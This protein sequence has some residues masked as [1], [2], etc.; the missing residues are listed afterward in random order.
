M[1]YLY[2]I[3][4]IFILFCHSNTCNS[5]V[6][7]YILHDSCI[8]ELYKTAYE[9]IKNDDIYILRD[10]QGI[11][12]RFPIVDCKKE[13]YNLSDSTLKNLVNIEKFLAKIKNP[14]II[15]VHTDGAKQEIIKGLKN[16][17]VS[18][19]IA[20]NI[21]TAVVNNG[22]IAENNRILSVGYGEFLPLKNTPNNGGK[23]L[24]RVDIIVLCNVSGE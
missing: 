14:V 21:R 19:V 20:D 22:D 7:R 10:S 6:F 1:R 18:T 13:Y 8:S 11:I 2:K 9:N 4:C 17:E 23:L 3:I 24:N 15:E 5:E 12:I 16:W